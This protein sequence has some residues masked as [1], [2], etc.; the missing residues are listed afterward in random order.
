M[1]NAENKID[2]SQK[3]IILITGASKGIGRAIAT[4]SAKHL[5]QSSTI[6]LLARSETGLKETK[7]QIKNINS[8]LNI[9]TYVTDLSQPHL[10]EY[11][12]LLENVLTQTDH[13]NMKYG[14]IFHNAAHIGIL[15]KATHLTDLT[16]WRQY[17]DLNLFSTILL[18]NAFIRNFRTIVQQ[19][20]TVNMTSLL[21]RSPSPNM[22]MYG[23]GKAARDLFFKV[24]AVEEPKILVL[25]YS[26]GPV[27]TEMFN[28][29]MESAQSESVRKSFRMIKETEILTTVQTVHSLLSILKTGDYKS[30][31]TIECFDRFELK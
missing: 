25:N 12:E 21:G 1:N 16:A 13:S 9:L 20:L 4:E 28:S 31:E 14:M 27:N 3:S 6:I 10:E 22:G 19:I 29:A 2:F 7:L 30:G 8:S 11:N 15:K 17:Y 23:S 26:P 24:L 5:N 18:N